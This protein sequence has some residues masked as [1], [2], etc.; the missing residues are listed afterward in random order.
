[1]GERRFRA[2]QLAGLKTIPAAIKEATAELRAIQLSENI[3]RQELST[4]EIARAVE[5]LKADGRSREDVAKALGWSVAQISA[6]GQILTMDPKLLK[7]ADSSV[8][9]RA[10]ND[11]NALWKKDS[12]AV[13]VFIDNTS[14][15]QITRL[16]VG[17]LK[18]SGRGRCCGGMGRLQSADRSEFL[19]RR[20]LLRAKARD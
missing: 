1:M 18:T 7:L 3:Q 2:A 11:L 9:A 8:Q 17:A 13:E 6:F 20:I 10:L 19:R 14:P 4:L 16:S 12:A 5:Q 15:E